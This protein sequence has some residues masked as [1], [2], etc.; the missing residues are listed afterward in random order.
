M[1]DVIERSEKIRVDIRKLKPRK[2]AEE[3]IVQRLSK[4]IQ[5]KL[6]CGIDINDIVTVFKTHRVNMSIKKLESYLDLQLSK[7]TDS[8]NVNAGEQK[9]VSSKKS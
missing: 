3:I 7:K 6:H 2:T 1:I 5:H 4:L 9:R 8:A